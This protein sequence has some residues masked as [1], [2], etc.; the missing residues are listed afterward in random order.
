MNVSTELER[1]LAMFLLDLQVARK[2]TST[3]EH[4]SG[5]T[6]KFAKWWEEAHTRE[7]DPVAV[8]KEDV[9]RWI[10]YLREN[11]AEASVRNFFVGFRAFCKWAV[12]EEFLE[13]DPTTGIPTPEMPASDKKILEPDQI[14]DVLRQ[15]DKE[16]NWRD[17]AIVALFFES[18]MRSREVCELKH[19]QIDWKEQVIVLG[20]ANTKTKQPRLT[21]LGNQTQRFLLRMGANRSDPDDYV[22]LTRTGRPYNRSTLYKVV[23]KI[24]KRFGY[25]GIHPHLMRHSA[26]SA[27]SM[28][29]MDSRDLDEVF[30][31]NDP[32]TSKIYTRKIAKQ[33]AVA[34]QRQ[35]NPL[36]VVTTRKR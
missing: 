19:S 33:R 12:R 4:Y 17:A 14:A 32:R 6:R 11:Y 30:G 1:F 13:T 5:A 24:F 7:F 29:G 8:T 25:E 35:L 26:A 2:S 3:I 15:L 27:L 34:A 9:K 18:G 23:N 10:L 16:R 28:A 36:D 20:A 31:W 21:L 22:F